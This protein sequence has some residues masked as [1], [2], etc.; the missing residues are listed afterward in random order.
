MAETGDAEGEEPTATDLTAD[1]PNVAVFSDLLLTPVIL[2]RFPWHRY[3]P[4]AHSVMRKSSKEKNFTM[5]RTC[6][7]GKGCLEE[8]L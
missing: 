1:P 6:P 4:I 3:Q 7:S 5:V 2:L 8:R